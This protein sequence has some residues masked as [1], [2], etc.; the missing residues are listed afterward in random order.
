MK[1]IKNE[2]INLAAKLKSHE[3]D[4]QIDNE[5]DKELFRELFNELTELL[6]IELKR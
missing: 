6:R 5:L 1:E 4:R 3:L 2:S